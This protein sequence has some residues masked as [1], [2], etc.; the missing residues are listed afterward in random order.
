MANL[1]TMLALFGAQGAGG[2]PPFDP[3]GTPIRNPTQGTDYVPDPEQGEEIVVTPQNLTPDNPMYNLLPREEGPAQITQAPPDTSMMPRTAASPQEIA[4]TQNMTGLPEHKG[5]F[6]MKGTLR[7]VLGTLGDALGDT[8]MFAKTR[9]RERAGDAMVGYNSDDPVAQQA[10][11]SRLAQVNP[12]LAL[13]VQQQMQMNQYRKEQAANAAST[14]QAA[15][16]K[17]GTADFAKGAAIYGQ[18]LLGMIQAGQYDKR[19]L[20]TIATRYNLGDE[21]TAPDQPDAN[22]ASGRIA[23][24][25]TVNQQENVA[26]GDRRQTEVERHNPVME[27]VAL[28]NAASN[29]QR[30]SRAPAGRAAPNPTAASMAAEIMRKPVNQRTQDEK[31]LVDD[32]VGRNKGKKSSAAQQIVDKLTGGKTAKPSAQGIAVGQIVTQNGRRYRKAADGSFKPL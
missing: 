4:G 12:E 19:L 6:G 31:D 1:S 23:A 9:E 13:K 22:W 32:F 30:A 25:T 21:Y 2:I 15:S 5:M 14:A 27:S 28:R 20:D 24:A 7:N 11:L 16:A 18:A 17:Q 8:D 29:A 10:A 3:R 26:L